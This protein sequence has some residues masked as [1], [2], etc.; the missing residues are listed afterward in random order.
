LSRPVV[1][2]RLG[3]LGDT[4]VALPCFRL[5]ADRFAQT[6]RIALT[7]MPHVKEAVP[8]ESILFDGGFIDD[9]IGYPLRMRDVGALIELRRKLRATGADTLV[10]LQRR[11][12][13]WHVHRDIL[14]FR[15]CGFR[16]IVGAPLTAD[17]N[18][19]RVDPATGDIEQEA[20]RLAR[21][22][23]PLGKIDLDDPAAWDLRLTARERARADELLE[24]LEG[25]PFLAISVGGKLAVQ[26]WGDGNWSELLRRVA[27]KLAL[28][29]V[30]VGG[31][32][33][34]ARSLRLA[35]S[36]TA[37]VLDACGRL[38]PRETAALLRR[39]ALFVG[40]DS[41]PMHLAAAGGLR[42]VSLF[43]SRDPP[44]IWHPVGRHHR[45]FHDVR[46]VTNITPDAVASAVLAVYS[47]LASGGN[48]IGPG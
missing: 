2:F 47:E 18:F 41:G 12:R 27:P 7:N 10:Y 22:M 4:V 29:L 36:W 15:A 43:G 25:K 14:F 1:I 20:S 3:S 24:P 46:G 5:I 11:I 45:T 38:T 9:C 40:H 8:L 28:P 16:Q 23:A 6:K 48:L 21:C 30:F 42:C 35:A 32:D 34:S 33:D 13:L 31:A 19:G 39:A 17:L 44:R 37:P 26:D